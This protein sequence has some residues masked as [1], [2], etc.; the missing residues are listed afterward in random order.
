MKKHILFKVGDLFDI[1]PTEIYKMTNSDLYKNSGH[2]PVVS[3]S[4]TNNGIGGYVDLE[5][6]EKG[7]IITFSDTTTGADT[8][9]YQ[10]SPF[11]GYP[12]V[13]GMYPYNPDVWTENIF[14]DHIH[15]TFYI[16]DK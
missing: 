3:N 11:I 5:P 13:Q 14:F 6:T 10:K 12:H 8:M 4:S 1:H 7:N 2:T 9:F 15:N 16:W